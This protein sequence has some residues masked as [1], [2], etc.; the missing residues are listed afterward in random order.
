MQYTNQTIAKIKAKVLSKINAELAL[1]I[2]NEE[3]D[4]FLEKYG[5]IIDDKETMLVNTRTM[6]I[7]VLGDFAGSI[8]SYKTAL[9]KCGIDERNVVFE[10][11][12]EKIKRLGITRLE[13]SMEYSDIILGPIAHKISGIGDNNSF[14]SMVEKEPHKFPRVIKAMANGII[15]LSITSFKDSIL[16]TRFFE[17]L[18]C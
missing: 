13:Y 8:N 7:L 4:E 10:N 17:A 1:A 14:L 5:V 18:N 16:K 2:D 3:L 15:K 11:D 12:Y 9:K 6:K